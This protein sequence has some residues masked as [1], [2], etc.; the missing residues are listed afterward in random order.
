MS[1]PETKKEMEQL[2]LLKPNEMPEISEMLT[3]FF[4]PKAP[5]KAAAAQQ[6]QNKQTK[7]RN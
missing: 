7:K 3:S 5:P 6:K 2:N 1:D 4:S